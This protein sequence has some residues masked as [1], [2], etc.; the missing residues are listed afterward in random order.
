MLQKSRYHVG[1][2][3]TTMPALG[4]SG[5]VDIYGSA[6][7]ALAEI[8]GGLILS[9]IVDPEA[10]LTGYVASLE[11]DMRTANP[12]S[13][14]SRTVRLDATVHQAM[15][16]CF[17]GRAQVGGRGY[18][19]AKAPGLQAVL[20]RFL[21]ARGYAA[22]VDDGGFS[23]SGTGNLDNGSMLSPEQYLLDLDIMEALGELQT[24]PLI[25]AEGEVAA[26]LEAAVG[27]GGNF[28]T[29]EHT[30]EHF[31]D[32]V[33]ESLCFNARPQAFLEDAVVEKCH[34][35]YRETLA[36]YKPASHSDQV[37]RQLR[38]ILRR[39]KTAAARGFV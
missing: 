30:L 27:N 25:P 9:H 12:S 2:L 26:R 10:P 8:V 24:A 3:I 17:G 22:L 29:E 13:A 16:K 31:R 11:L 34:A 37:L 7:L 23:Y 35:R 4:A 36:A 28:L 32:E 21:K 6:V 38:G 14:T 15:A 39:A 18:V 5:P 20:E 33:R 1:S 19:S